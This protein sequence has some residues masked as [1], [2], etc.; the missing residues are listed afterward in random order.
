M[1]DLS[2]FPG[3]DPSLDPCP[4][5]GE[6]A[7]RITCGPDPTNPKRFQAKAECLNCAVTLLCV[8]DTEQE[9]LGT[10]RFGWNVRHFTHP[11]HQ[12]RIEKLERTL[13]ET[14]RRNCELGELCDKLTGELQRDRS[15]REIDLIGDLECL[16]EEAQKLR[17]RRDELT[18]KLAEAG[19]ERVTLD[20]VKVNDRLLVDKHGTVWDPEGEVMPP[21]GPDDSD[22]VEYGP[23]A[24]L[25]DCHI[26]LPSTYIP[27]T[28]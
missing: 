15:E 10:A 6:K 3:A 2:L 13:L 28:E 5:C 8:D 17:A 1:A 4:F 9:V 12:A 27:G 18:R 25:R 26:Y 20:T 24:D 7:A 16:E 19:V 23:F 11:A 21:P 14:N 22:K